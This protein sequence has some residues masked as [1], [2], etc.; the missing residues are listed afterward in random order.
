MQTGDVLIV[1]HA[2]TLDV[3]TRQIQGFDPRPMPEFVSFVTK[4]R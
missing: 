3:M 2:A 4:V 1:G